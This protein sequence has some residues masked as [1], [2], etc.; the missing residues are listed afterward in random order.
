MRKL[1]GIFILLGFCFS[2]VA[3]KNWSRKDK[4]DWDEGDFVFY[5]KDY[6]RAQVLLEPLLEKDLD[7]LPIK[8]ELG[9]SYV[10]LGIQTE[11]ALSL[12][13]ACQKS[14]HVESTFYYARALHQSHQFD[15]SLAAYSKYQSYQ[16]TEQS[17]LLVNKYVSE[18]ERAKKS[19]RIPIDVVVTNMGPSVNGPYKEYVP[20]VTGNNSDLYFTSRRSNS[21]GQ[22]IDLNDEY[23]E[24]IYHSSQT[25]GIWSQADQ[26]GNQLNTKSHDA[27]VS[28]SPDGLQMIIYRTNTNLMG[29]DLYIT[30]KTGAGWG[31]AIKLGKQI[32]SPYQEASACFGRNNETLYFSS[33]RPGGFGGKDLYRVVKLPNDEWSL[34]KNLGPTINTKYD[35][36]APFMDVNGVTL[37]FSSNGHDNIGGYD[38]F[39]TKLLSPEVW[40]QPINI[41]Y[42]VNTVFDDIY[43]A[44]DAGGR[45]GYYSSDQA[46]GFGMQDI[47][48]IDFILR[49]ETQL[50]VLG[51]VMDA[52]GNP[53][54]ATI[55]VVDDSNKQIQGIY[56]TKSSNGSYVMI[57]NPLVNYRFMIEADDCESV[58]DE[59][60]LTFPEENNSE[61]KTTPYILRL[62]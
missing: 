43:L 17:T 54:D 29:G 42:P 50:I 14:G 8:F 4:Q 36:D 10:Q 9:A 26:L 55:T 52:D 3:Q 61:I 11:K 12:L 39:T 62:K 22:L 51:E 40:K 24:D 20:V 59:V 44:L 25:N 21:T 45:R 56:K 19:T 30:R 35:E 6:K 37:Y 41:G 32:N 28:I 5:Q 34:P 16:E 18:C 60:T 23:F 13:A 46:G 1:I 48:S 58:M 53:L 47:Y 38:V 31:E 7:F 2:G 27:T 49:Q 57:L 33:N 15:E